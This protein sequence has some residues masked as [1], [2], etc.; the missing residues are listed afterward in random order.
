M[1]RALA[2]GIRNAH[3]PIMIGNAARGFIPSKLI[4]IR[5]GAYK[6]MPIVI[7]APRQKFA[8]IAKNSSVPERP[9]ASPPPGISFRFVIT[10]S[11]AAAHRAP[12]IPT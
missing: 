2:T 9:R 7:S 6:P 5:H 8:T 4:R 1:N 3:D 12:P 10:N 11:A